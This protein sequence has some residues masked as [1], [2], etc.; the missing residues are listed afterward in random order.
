MA[1]RVHFEVGNRE[2]RREM[3]RKANGLVTEQRVGVL[4]N[5]SG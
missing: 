4:Q 3:Q 5:A 1:Y 2:W